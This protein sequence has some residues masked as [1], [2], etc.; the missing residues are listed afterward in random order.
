MLFSI[1]YVRK[2]LEQKF[3]ASGLPAIFQKGFV[4]ELCFVFSRSITR[5]QQDCLEATEKFLC[6]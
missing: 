5:N 1:G 6:Q 2:L 3:A 4:R